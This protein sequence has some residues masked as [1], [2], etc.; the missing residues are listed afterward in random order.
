MGARAFLFRDPS[1][2]GSKANTPQT[3]P[4]ARLPLVRGRDKALKRGAF[5]SHSTD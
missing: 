4:F 2:I 5:A 3:Q 1:Q